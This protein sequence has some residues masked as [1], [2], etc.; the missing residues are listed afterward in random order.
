VS[1]Q[2]GLRERKKQQTRAAIA[3]AAVELFASRG[4]EAVKV[5][6]IA[7][8]ANVSEATVFNYFPTK[9]DLI[10]SRLGDLRADLLESVR[11]RD[12]AQTISEAF[13]DF[14]FRQRPPGRTPEED[15]SL[16]ALTRI[17]YDSPSLLAREREITSRNTRELAALIAEDVGAPPE[18]VGPWVVANALMGVHQA[19]IVFTRE[20]VLAGVPGPTIAQRIRAQA[21]KAFAALD[22]GLAAYPPR[23]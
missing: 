22:A 15:E 12:R 23:G 20:Q 8:R 16:L 14:L 3:T 1:T 4:F 19:L 11:G 2:T 13:R 5:A 7:V 18:D 9:E 10:Y 6:E 17:I 21:T